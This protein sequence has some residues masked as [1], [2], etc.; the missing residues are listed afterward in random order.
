MKRIRVLAGVFVL[1]TLSMAAATPAE[2]ELLNAVR[3]GDAAAVK[4]L[5][6][7][8]VNANAKFRYDRM[9]LSFACDRGNVEIVKLLLEAGAEVNAKDTFYG[10]TALT[11]AANKGHADIVGLLLGRGAEGKEEVLLNAVRRGD[12]AM[13]RA[14]LDKG[15]F[16]SETLSTALA[17][18]N[19]NSQTEIASLLT[20][21]G[22]VPPPPANFQVDAETLA[23]YAGTYR[24]DAGQELVLFVKDGKLSGGP[25]G[26]PMLL[27]ALDK[28]T[29][30]PEAID[31]MT[32]HF[33]VENG[34][35]VSLTVR[36]MGRDSLYKKVEEKP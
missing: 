15:G 10:A 4:A 21:A 5:L 22:A 31:G 1:A 12:K 25:A 35:A 36:Q 19:R 33:S 8:G 3:Q 2:E 30:R 27:G 18:A 17:A 34:K 7:R 13:A 24:S 23:Q 9:P 29:F 20:D 16:Q 26:Q 6:E 14:V 28:V 32:V 11:W